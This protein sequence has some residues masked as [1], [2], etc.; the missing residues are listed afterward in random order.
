MNDFFLE[1]D[2]TGYT[3]LIRAAMLGRRHVLQALLDR[4]ASI[5][6]Q[7]RCSDIFAYNSLR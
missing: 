3:A 5:N 2:V 4:G 1:S 6:Y 7:N